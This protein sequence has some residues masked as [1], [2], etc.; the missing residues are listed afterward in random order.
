MVGIAESKTGKEMKKNN[1]TNVINIANL[2]KGS[3]LVV[4]KDKENKVYYLKLI[5]Q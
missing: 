2:Q 1:P 3:Y 5:K 4:V